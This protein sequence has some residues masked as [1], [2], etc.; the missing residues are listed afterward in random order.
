MEMQQEE[1][2]S[3]RKTPKLGAAADCKQDSSG[4]MPTPLTLPAGSA[5]A[6][7]ADD[8]TEEEGFECEVCGRVF[9]DEDEAEVHE[10]S[11][12]VK[13]EEIVELHR[14]NNKEKHRPKQRQHLKSRQHKIAASAAEAGAVLNDA[15]LLSIILI[16][17]ASTGLHQ[18]HQVFMMEACNTTIGEIARQKRDELWAC[19]RQGIR[20][21]FSAGK[22]REATWI[23]VD[24]IMLVSP[25]ADQQ[26]MLRGHAFDESGKLESWELRYCK[27]SRLPPSFG[28]LVCSGTL[29]LS[30]NELESFP[31]GFSEI[32]VAG[33]LYLKYSPQLTGVPENF[34]NVKGRVYR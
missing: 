22:D 4:Q 12:K 34:P 2:G 24:H 25:G 10:A 33:D 3:P 21:L 19:I 29:Y 16:I 30:Y 14:R 32:T 5:R 7:A 27:I 8:S 11:C 13:Q 31:E 28:A 15:N 23:L 20:Q 17:A 18:A 26:K 6:E 1:L 9:D